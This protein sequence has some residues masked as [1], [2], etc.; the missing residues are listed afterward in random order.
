MSQTQQAFGGLPTTDADIMQF[1]NLVQKMVNDH[2]QVPGPKSYGW[3]QICPSIGGERYIRIEQY[4]YGHKSVYCF[5][6]RD[7]G[8]IMKSASWQR[9]AKHARGN[10]FADRPLDGCTVYGAMYLR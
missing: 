5:I 9:P 4:R 10:I 6:E 3:T 1:C 7:T 8:A 2:N